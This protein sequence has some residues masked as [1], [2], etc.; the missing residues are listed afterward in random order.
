MMS[1]TNDERVFDKPLLLESLSDV[2]KQLANDESNQN[3]IIYVVGASAAVLSG[4]L[5][6]KTKDC[7]LGA[8]EPKEFE[9]LLLDVGA[10]VAKT[11]GFKKIEW[12][13]AEAYA[14]NDIL[15]AGWKSRTIMILR[16]G[17]LT[18]F[19]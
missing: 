2:A 11:R 16:T 5:A 12:L 10:N 6:R 19:L 9:D 17:V 13:N 15:P 3:I 1:E 8:V 4:D 14:W 18:V 7:D